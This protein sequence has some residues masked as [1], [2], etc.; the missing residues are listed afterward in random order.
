[1]ATMT[2]PLSSADQVQRFIFDES[3][4]R[5]E[6]VTLQQAYREAIATQTLHPL[7]SQLLGEFLAAV[8][9]LS[10]SLKFDGIISLQARGDGPIPLIMAECSH[11]KDIRGIVRSADTNLDALSIDNFPTLIGKGVL[12]ITIEP[13]KGER[14]QGIV[15]LE[16]ASLSACIEDYFSQSE[17]LPTRVWLAADAERCGGLLLQVLPAMAD[18]KGERDEYWNLVCHL[19]GTLRPDELLHTEQE[20][21]LFRLFNETP[22]R[23]FPPSPVRF[24]CSCSRARSEN[25]LRSLGQT[26]VQELLAERDLITIDCEFCGQTYSF[27]EK[28]VAEIFAGEGDSLH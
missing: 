21:L 15:P 6:L 13:D 4:I 7:A 23:L 5:G 25:A 12:F 19:A 10:G 14:Y 2:E 20:T 27:G 8:T 18:A 3:A 17:Q 28:D 24:A 22:V 11:Q 26:E 1:M 9:L 16:G